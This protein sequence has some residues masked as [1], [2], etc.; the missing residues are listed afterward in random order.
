MGA[1]ECD[2]IKYASDS[3]GNLKV[4]ICT[5]DPVPEGEG[6]DSFKQ[7]GYVIQPLFTS[8]F[9]YQRTKNTNESINY[10]IMC[11]LVFVLGNT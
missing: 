10:S 9:F 2:H 8:V 11:F 4:A 1:E 6:K 3:E 7:I 5:S